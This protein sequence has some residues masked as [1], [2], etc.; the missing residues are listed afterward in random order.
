MRHKKE[1]ATG[2][3]TR[4]SGL[5]TLKR[6]LPKYKPLA[7]AIAFHDARQSHKGLKGGVGAGKTYALAADDILV[8]FLNAPNFHLCTSPTYDNAL[9]TVVPSL[10]QLCEESEIEYE[11]FVSKNTFRITHNVKG[12]IKI[13]NILIF[14]ADKPQFLKGINAASGSMNEPFTQK[15]E[16]FKI[17]WERIRVKSERLSRTWAGTAE[18]DKMQWGWEYFEELT[19]DTNEIYLDTITT[20]ENDYLDQDYVK[21]LESIYDS[22]S[23]EVYMLG[24]CINLRAGKTYYAF[25]KAI[26]VKPYLP[27]ESDE[28]LQIVISFD[29]NV[30]PMCAVEIVFERGVYHQIREYK[31]SSSRT[32]E[33]CDMIIDDIKGRYDFKRTSFIITGDATGVRSGTRSEHDDFAIIKQRFDEFAESLKGIKLNVDLIIPKANPLVRDRVNYVNNLFEKKKFLISSECIETIKDFD[34]VSWKKGADKFSLDKSQR[35][36]THLSDAVG[37]SLWNTQIFIYKDYMP[38][39]LTTMFRSRI[40]RW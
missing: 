26:N 29:F 11:W 8:S 20:M 27:V 5:Q 38:R 28:T 2:I 31:I 9:V 3:I 12:K 24:K 36:L 37:Y 25:D 33:L 13:A 18:P 35:E 7:K 40:H 15:S 4:E 22:K 10:I 34:L 14:G 21:G 16:A 23:R 17:W 32:D 39:D 19:K 30:D 6:I 1:F